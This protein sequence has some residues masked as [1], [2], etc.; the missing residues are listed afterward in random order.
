MED[1]QRDQRHGG[2]T[3]EPDR[4]G[5]LE[6]PVAERRAEEQAAVERLD[7]KQVDEGPEGVDP[8]PCPPW[9]LV[10]AIPSPP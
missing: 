3:E 8:D 2:G 5:D 9:P 4:A 7:G 6:P 10:P 1:E